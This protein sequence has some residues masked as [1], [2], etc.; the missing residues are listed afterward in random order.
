MTDI[1]AGTLFQTYLGPIARENSQ[2]FDLGPVSVLIEHRKVTKASLLASFADDP[3]K[4]AAATA[5][6][7]ADL[8]DAGLSFHVVGKSDD[9][10]YL[11]FDCLRGAPHYHYNRRPTA[12][13]AVA[14]IEVKY[15]SISN[16]DPVDWT[17]NRLASRLPDMLSAAGAA[18][19]AAELDGVVVAV[20]VRE[21]LAFIARLEAPEATGEF[22]E[23]LSAARS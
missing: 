19:L 3:E 16:G 1:S 20:A 10:E 7:P 6:T 13:V 18:D 15:D 22:A 21:M 2:S 14:N 12:T 9:H 5:G 4:L 17:I 11:R 23:A 8:D